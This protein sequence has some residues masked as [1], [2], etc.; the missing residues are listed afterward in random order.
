MIKKMFAQLAV[1]GVASL[2]LLGLG[3]VASLLSGN[4]ELGGSSAG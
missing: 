4:P 3:A 1:L 2:A